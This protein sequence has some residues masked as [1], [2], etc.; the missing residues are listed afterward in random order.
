M[1]DY[2]VI[3]KELVLKYYDPSDLLKNVLPIYEVTTSEMMNW[4]RG[5]VPKH[6]IDEHDVFD[7]LKECGFP[8]VQKII[9]EKVCI[10]EEDKEEGIQAEYDE[11][12][13]GRV[14]VWNLYE[15][16]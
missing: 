14:L 8:L 5:V 12:E 7:V 16:L 11:E 13:V 15:K 10:V 3:M 6:P 9:Y 2:K 1:E 4:F